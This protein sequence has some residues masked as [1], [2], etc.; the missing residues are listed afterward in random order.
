MRMCPLLAIAPELYSA[1][2][3]APLKPRL[4]QTNV[5]CGAKGTCQGLPAQ[6][7]THAGQEEAHLAPNLK[8]CLQCWVHTI[9]CTEICLDLYRQ[10][11]SR[12]IDLNGLY[13]LTHDFEHTLDW[14]CVESDVLD[15]SMSACQRRLG[16]KVYCQTEHHSKVLSS[17]DYLSTVLVFAQ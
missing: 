8:P 11:N 10:T 14:P 17:Q 2:S 7:A 16:E 5:L 6:C 12:L 1:R 4:Q 15:T 9:L 3:L 13:G